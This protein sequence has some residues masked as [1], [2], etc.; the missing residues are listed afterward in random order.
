MENKKNPTDLSGAPSYDVALA[1]AHALY[2]KKGIDVRLFHVEETTVIA[3]YYLLATGRASTHLNALA[4]E[5]AYKLGEAGVKAYRTEGRD[6]GEWL[7]VDFGSV[8]VHVFSRDAREYY[9]LERL[10]PP[11]G[12]V[13]LTP[14]F[15][16]WK[17]NT[18]AGDTEA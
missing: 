9:H 11:E 16:E 3:D 18:E 5:V 13:D 1:A 15:E 6:G 12:E 10:L 2:M 8:I 17:N 4:D 7:L 14:M